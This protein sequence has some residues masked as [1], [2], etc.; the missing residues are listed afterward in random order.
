MV[1]GWLKSAIL[2]V[3]SAP[4]PSTATER[5]HFRHETCVNQQRPTRSER[6]KVVLDQAIL[7]LLI[8]G[9]QRLPWGIKE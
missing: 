5:A 6:S 1:N 3:D 9:R 7:G 4:A 8:N 2:D